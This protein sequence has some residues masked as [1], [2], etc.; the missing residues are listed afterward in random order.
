MGAHY[1]LFLHISKLLPLVL[2]YCHFL[3]RITSTRL[4]L[5]ST[6]PKSLFSVWKST[7][8]FACDTKRCLSN[9]F[10]FLAT[11]SQSIY[12]SLCKPTMASHAASSKWT[13][14]NRTLI[15]G[16]V[17][18]MSNNVFRSRFQMLVLKSKELLEWVW[19]ADAPSARRIVRVLIDMESC[20]GHDKSSFAKKVKTTMVKEGDDIVLRALGTEQ[21][22]QILRASITVRTHG[23]K[24]E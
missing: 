23:I 5:L 6:C 2:T 17:E 24:D 15:V 18:A 10:S 4:F 19:A 9:V 12:P 11:F 7:N 14:G 20:R 21:K 1:S 13:S 16:F 3:K 8:P 22:R